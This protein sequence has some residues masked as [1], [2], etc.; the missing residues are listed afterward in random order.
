M[1]HPGTTLSFANAADG[2]S[3]AVLEQIVVAEI[4]DASARL[5]GELSAAA[6]ASRGSVETAETA[7]D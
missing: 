6:I 1:T 2:L 4:H 7:H 5:T 3:D